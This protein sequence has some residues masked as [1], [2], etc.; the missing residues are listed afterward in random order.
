MTVSPTTTGSGWILVP[1][2][3]ATTGLGV[4][5]G[6]VQEAPQV[7]VCPEQQL[8]FESVQMRLYFV[9]SA[10]V[11]PDPPQEFSLQLL[12]VQV[13]SAHGSGVGVEGGQPVPESQHSYPLEQKVFSGPALREF[14]APQQP[15]PPAQVPQPVVASTRG[16]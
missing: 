10:H 3:V 11:Y 13:T 8:E 15:A 9:V 4:G 7:S 12:Y 14:P 2:H 5:V 1:I 16:D 6:V